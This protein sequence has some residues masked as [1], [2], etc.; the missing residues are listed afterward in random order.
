MEG[1][2]YLSI[3]LWLNVLTVLV[4][5]ATE[6]F[7]F[8]NLE[9]APWVDGVVVAIIAVINLIRHFF[10]DVKMGPVTL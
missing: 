3:T 8:G 10:P 5:V 7:G 4:A 1:K 6:L 9:P 2:W